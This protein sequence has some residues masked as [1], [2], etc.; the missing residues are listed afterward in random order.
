[1]TPNA[2]TWTTPK[3][4]TKFT[5]P[6]SLFSLSGGWTTQIVR[7]GLSGVIL[8]RA[9]NGPHCAAL[10]S[11]GVNSTSTSPEREKRSEN[12][13][14]EGKRTG[15]KIWAVQGDGRSGGQGSP[16][17]SFSF[18]FTPFVFSLS[19][20][21]YSRHKKMLVERRRPKWWVWR[22]GGR[23]GGA[24]PVFGMTSFSKCCFFSFSFFFFFFFFVFF[25]L[26]FL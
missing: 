1:M 9:R 11:T 10:G 3:V 19:F 25:S 23:G 20:Q 18:S 21:V 15:A 14:G 12:G 22:E 17:V 6:F 5:G 24:M 2:K 16:S 7:L 13:A 4:G 8:W 26:F